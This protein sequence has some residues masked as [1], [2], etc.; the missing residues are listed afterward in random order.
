MLPLLGSN[1]FLKKVS[2][3]VI[4][5]GLELYVDRSVLKLIGTHLPLFPDAGIAREHI[6][7]YRDI[8]VILIKDISVD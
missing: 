6:K 3:C 1:N 2:H 4:L 8:S 5:A 7:T